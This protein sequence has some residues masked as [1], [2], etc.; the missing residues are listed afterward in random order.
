MARLATTHDVF[1]AIAEP[2]RR[3]ILDLL[4]AGERA[5]GDIVD[6]LRMAQPQV[7]K[8]LRV[9]SEVRLVTVRQDGRRRL[10]SLSAEGLEPIHRWVSQFESHWDKQLQSI[11]AA[12]EAR[13]RQAQSTSK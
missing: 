12:A 13:A 10:Y 7:S 11:K 8:H 5:V 6:A 4:A 3:Q 9:L 2:A 1:N